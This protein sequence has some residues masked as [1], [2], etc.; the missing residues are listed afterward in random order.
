MGNI[1]DPAIAKAIQIV[2]GNKLFP[3]IKDIDDGFDFVFDESRARD[4]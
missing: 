1:V 4:W 3:A 2:E